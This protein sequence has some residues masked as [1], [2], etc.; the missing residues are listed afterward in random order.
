MKLITGLRIMS[1]IIFW[2][3]LFLV[4]SNIFN[5]SQ[6]I[7]KNIAV[8]TVFILFCYLLRGL[9]D[10]KIALCF[11]IIGIAVFLVVVLSGILESPVMIFTVLG[12]GLLSII[13]LGN[14]MD[15][16]ERGSLLQVILFIPMIMLEKIYGKYPEY[17]MILIYFL[18]LLVYLLY[19]QLENNKEYLDLVAYSTYM[20]REKVERHSGLVS[21]GIVFVILTFGFLF[22]IFGH[23]PLFH[24]WNQMIQLIFAIVLSF[25]PF[26]N[27]GAAFQNT[28]EMDSPS[29]DDMGSNNLT[30][31]GDDTVMM[32]I[33]LGCSL[34]LLAGLLVGFIL[35]LQKEKSKPEIPEEDEVMNLSASEPKKKRITRKARLAEDPTYVARKQVRKMYKKRIKKNVAQPKVFFGTQTPAEQAEYKNQKGSQ[36]QNVFVETYEKA[37]YSNHEITK[38]DINKMQEH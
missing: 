32:Y 12:Y 15:F 37:R 21:A 26:P 5:V 31:S 38:E 34:L 36:I 13:A 29:V 6:G 7:E 8:F 9:Q 10:R 14:Q 23:L 2:N 18:Y 30:V 1:Q 28:Y 24:G 20:E 19:K 3:C 35:Y 11:H 17:I 33:G 16:M 4:A 25:L 22:S 27:I